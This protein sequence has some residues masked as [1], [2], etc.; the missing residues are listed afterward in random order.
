M[1]E[2]IKPILIILIVIAII[3][4]VAIIFKPEPTEPKE[5]V[6]ERAYKDGLISLTKAK[7]ISVY[8]EEEVYVTKQ[9]TGE[10]KVFGPG[11]INN[12]IDNDEVENFIK[13]I[14][15]CPLHTPGPSNELPLNERLYLYDENDNELMWIK[16]GNND[17]TIEIYKDKVYYEVENKHI[18]EINEFLKKYINYEF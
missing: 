8:V 1:K 2:V 11:I 18:D 14:K 5:L 6:R 15:D 10:E 3:V 7:K 17:H 9:T 4:G 13:L 16:V 12:I